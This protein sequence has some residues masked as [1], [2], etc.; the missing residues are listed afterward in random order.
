MPPAD[1]QTSQPVRA[2]APEP[3]R[4]ADGNDAERLR[5]TV[6]G[7][8]GSPVR[9][10]GSRLAVPVQ[11]G[12]RPHQTSGSLFGGGEHSSGSRGADGGTL[13]P[14][15]SDVTDFGFR[16]DRTVPRTGYTWWYVDAVSDDGENALVLILFVGSVFSPYYAWK[17]WDDP[18]DHC[19]L[20]VALY[21][22]PSRWSMTERGRSSRSRGRY[23]YRVGRSL[24]SSNGAELTFDIHER[25]MPL[26]RAVQGRVKV[27][28]PYCNQRTF[29]LTQ[30]GKHTWRPI[31]LSARVEVEFDKPGLSWSGHGYV[32]MNEGAEPL[33]KGFQY[34]DW[35]RIPMPDGKTQ[36]RYVTDPRGEPPRSLGLEWTQSGEVKEIDLEPAVDLP[37]TSVW[38]ISRRA[39]VVNGVEPKI[40]KT[41][42]D[43]PF[44]SRSL[45][46]YPGLNAPP[47]VHESVSGDRL[48]NGIVKCL[49]PF[50][51]PRLP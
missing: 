30:S 6:S 32:D 27:T 42:E 44:Y 25:G 9:D 13:R 7:D 23:A 11:E 49:L 3:N 18:E 15:S 1:D 31:C 37:D 5:E 33:E 26:P 10:G 2:D 29:S 24:I 43:T 17:G 35:A 48:S 50:R 22:R 8:G 40:L 41:L 45:V 34:W 47:A 14:V 51:M 38:R 19:A 28:M 16:F 21:G 12:G 4:H 46:T 20:N 39:G 36:I